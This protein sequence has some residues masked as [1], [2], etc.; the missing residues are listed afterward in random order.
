MGTN[1]DTMKTSTDVIYIAYSTK[2]CCDRHSEDIDFT[3]F[4][5]GDFWDGEKVCEYQFIP[6]TFGPE[7][8]DR[9]RKG[10]GF[11]ELVKIL[12][13]WRRRT[14]RADPVRVVYDIEDIIS[15]DGINLVAKIPPSR[16]H[17]EGPGLIIKALGETAEW[18]SRYARGM[19]EQVW[20]H[21]HDDSDEVPTYEQL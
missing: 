2:W 3:S 20:R 9:E 10:K 11:K 4:S 21:D 6:V 18:G 19:F 8:E 13:E 7:G 16:L 15:E 5:L 14:Y 1:R 12:T 17:R